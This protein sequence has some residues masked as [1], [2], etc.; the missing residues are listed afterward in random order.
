M[1]LRATLITYQLSLIGGLFEALAMF[2]GCWVLVI[3]LPHMWLTH[4]LQIVEVF[5]DAGHESATRHFVWY[6][7]LLLRPL[8]LYVLLLADYS[9]ER[10]T[11]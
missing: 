2:D 3:G 7:L 4:H 1:V 8:S 9:S 11:I 5:V 6:I 10:R